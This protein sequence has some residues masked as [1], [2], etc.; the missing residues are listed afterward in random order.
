M[1]QLSFSSLQVHMF[2]SIAIQDLRVRDWVRKLTVQPTCKHQQLI[3]LLQK[4]QLLR[5]LP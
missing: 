4:Q 5:L 3:G 1:V 2:A